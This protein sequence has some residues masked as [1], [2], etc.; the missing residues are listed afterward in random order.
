MDGDDDPNATVTPTNWLRWTDKNDNLH[1][2]EVTR[3]LPAVDLRRRVPF[4]SVRPEDGTAP[5]F[6]DPRTGETRRFLLV[7]GPARQVLRHTPLAILLAFVLLF[8]SAELSPAIDGFSDFIP[9]TGD[10]LLLLLAVLTPWP[11]LLWLVYETGI[12]SKD[13]NEN[14][15]VVIQYGLVLVLGILTLFGAFLVFTSPDPRGLEANIVFVS[16]Y[17]F[18]L[19]LG[20]QLFYEALLR[21]EN[22]LVGLKD[23]DDIVDDGSAYRRFLAD[24]TDSL[25]TRVFGLR[26]SSLFGA[27]FATQFAIVWTVGSGPMD[28]DYTVNLA[29]NVALNTVLVVAAFQFFVLVHY[30]NELLQDGGDYDDALGYDPFHVDAY[31]G[32]GDL[33]RFAVRY[34][35]LIGLGGLYLVYRLYINGARA[36]PEGG[37]LAFQEGLNLLVWSLNYV[38]PILFYGIVMFAWLYYAF[39]GLHLKMVRE[40]DTIVDRYQGTPTTDGAAGAGVP[41]TSLEGGPSWEDIKNL[42]E[43]PLDPGRLRSIISGNIIT[44]LLPLPELLVF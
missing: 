12:V 25:T 14:V 31:G 4:V 37:L 32:Y 10:W 44:L 40:K 3:V 11:V 35:F 43:W 18:T 13:R 16:G 33:G 24:L 22:L 42:P 17:L 28:L 39:W 15:G 30:F 5:A 19:L 20:G 6:E 1:L 8:G 29:T 9:P 27:L 36:L 23:E 34:N 41:A 7:E 2:T 21:T 26:A 38:G